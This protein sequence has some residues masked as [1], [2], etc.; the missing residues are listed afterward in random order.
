VSPRAT[1]SSYQGAVLWRPSP[2]PGMRLH[3]IESDHRVFQT[4]ECTFAS[5]A[6]H[7]GLI[8][9]AVGVIAGARG[10]VGDGRLVTPLLFLPP[11]RHETPRAGQTESF[12]PGQA[13]GLFADGSE[14][15]GAGSGIRT[16]GRPYGR[17]RP[18]KRSSA[19]GLAPFGAPVRLS[20]SVFTVLQVDRM[21]ERYEASAAPIYPPRLSAAGKEGR[22]QATF[23]VD[24]TGRVDLASVQV[25]ASDHPEFTESVRT[26]LGDMR[27]RPARR[28]GRAVRQLVEQRFSFR[29][30]PALQ[31][32]PQ[33]S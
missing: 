26:A 6:L 13:G 2:G 25:L 16:G 27:F 29:I 17:Q 12:R 28:G 32:P 5:L 23:V 14:L 1:L 8:W 33:I 9:L 11:D 19:I 3:L 22:V 20:D 4:A 7:A 15:D 18:G 31:V 30:A 21:V 10:M 24:T